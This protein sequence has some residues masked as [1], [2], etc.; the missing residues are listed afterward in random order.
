[1]VFPFDWQTQSQVSDYSK[2]G[3]T[4]KLGYDKTLLSVG[5]LW[6]DLPT[7]LDA[8]SISHLFNIKCYKSLI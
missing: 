4:L 7:T 5:E 6:L 2:Y 3:A 8:L 1:M